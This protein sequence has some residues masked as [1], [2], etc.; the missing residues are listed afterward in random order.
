MVADHLGDVGYY[1][2]QLRQLIGLPELEGNTR[3]GWT[4]EDWRGLDAKK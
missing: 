1:I 3:D 4:D 2:N